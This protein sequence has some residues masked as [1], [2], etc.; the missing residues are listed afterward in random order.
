MSC[1]VMRGV[2]MAQPDRACCGRPGPAFR[3][4]RPVSPACGF[5][6][7]S[8]LSIRLR[9]V[10]P[11]PGCPAR[12]PT[13]LRAIAR[14]RAGALAPARF[15]RLIALVCARARA[16]AQGAPLLPAPSVVFRAGPGAGGSGLRKPLPVFC[17]VFILAYL[18]E[19][20]AFHRCF[21]IT[22]C[23]EIEHS[24]KNTGFR[25]RR[26]PPPRIGSGA[27]GRAW[28][29]TA[30]AARQGREARRINAD[31]RCVHAVGPRPGPRAARDNACRDGEGRDAFGL[32]PIRTDRAPMYAGISNLENLPKANGIAVRGII[33]YG[34]S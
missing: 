22:S 11:P 5:R 6:H 28:A 23:Q 34:S 18:A 10:F 14:G 30:K 8:L 27:A 19:L 20:Q 32:G 4:F 21:F 9:F 25:D 33:L 15:A 29:A 17:S 3:V 2:R 16:R 26:R 31:A 12:G 1:F 7:R 13:M 24:G